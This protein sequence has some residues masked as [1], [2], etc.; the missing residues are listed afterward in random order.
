VRILC[1]VNDKSQHIQLH[2]VS[3]IPG[4]M[5]NLIS[6]QRLFATKSTVDFTETDCTIRMNSRTITGSAFHGIYLLDRYRSVSLGFAAY[7]TSDE[8]HQIYHERF[9]HAPEQ[10]I[11]ATQKHVIGLDLSKP[12][13]YSE[14]CDSC[15]RLRMKQSPHDGQIEPGRYIGDLIHSDSSW[16]KH[17]STT[18]RYFTI[19]KEDM[20]GWIDVYTYM[21]LTAKATLENGELYDHRAFISHKLDQEHQKTIITTS[22]NH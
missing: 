7:S 6:V 13:Q 19:F 14:I 9:A 17:G 8:L 21:D 1:K 5:T 11:V 12:I 15:A 20:S 4:A 18:A 22:K 3:Y 16:I 2:N 10:Q